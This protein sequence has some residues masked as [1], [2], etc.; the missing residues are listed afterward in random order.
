MPHLLVKL[1]QQEASFQSLG[2]TFKLMLL[3]GYTVLVMQTVAT[4]VALLFVIL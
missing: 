1:V 3:V 2:A 4:V